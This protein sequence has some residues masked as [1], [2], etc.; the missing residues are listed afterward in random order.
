MKVF[1]I[2]ITEILEKTVPKVAES[3][4]IAIAMVEED[5]QYGNI[6]LKDEDVIKVDIFIKNKNKEHENIEHC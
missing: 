1:D 5:Y 2:T 4:E 6:Q 3:E